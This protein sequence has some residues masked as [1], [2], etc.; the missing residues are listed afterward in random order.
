M[1]NIKEGMAQ[2]IMDAFYSTFTNER[3]DF[4][5]QKLNNDA[6]VNVLREVV[7]QLQYQSFHHTEDFYQLRAE[8]ILELCD[9]LKKL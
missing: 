9:E 3:Q 2:S 8:D 7:N 5:I 4:I 1:T 6:I